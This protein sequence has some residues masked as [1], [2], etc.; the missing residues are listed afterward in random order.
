[1]TIEIE[2]LGATSVVTLRGEI[3]AFTAPALRAD[4]RRLVEEHAP[5]LLVI[6]L[7]DVTFLDSAALGAIIGALRRIREQDGE[8][9][10]VR[11]QGPASRIFELTGLDSV[12]DVYAGREEALSAGVA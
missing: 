12:L 3:D 1:M 2:Q 6:D 10:I 9:R 8:L 4:L 5:S 7:A 11:P